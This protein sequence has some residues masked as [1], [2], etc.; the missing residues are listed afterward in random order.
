MRSSDRREPAT[1]AALSSLEARVRHLQGILGEF[2]ENLKFAWDYARSDAP[3]SLTKSRLIME[4]LL[5]RLYQSEMG[6]EPKKPLLGDMLADNQ[7]TRKIGRRIVVRMNTIRDM[8]NLGAHGITVAPDDAI[9]IIED[10][11]TVLEWYLARYSKSE[12]AAADEVAASD[13]PESPEPPPRDRANTAPPAGHG[14]EPHAVESGVRAR[15]ILSFKTSAGEDTRIIIDQDQTVVAGRLADLAMVFD[16]PKVSKLHAEFQLGGEGLA[17]YDLN[18]KNHVFVNDVPVKWLLL[19]RG[20]QVRL[21][22]SGPVI[23]VL[24][25][26]IVWPQT[27]SDMTRAQQPSKHG[28]PQTDGRPSAKTVADPTEADQPTKEMLARGSAKR[29]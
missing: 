18:S 21:S 3:S 4:T 9:R 17:V 5:V 14:E 29:L 27:E 19:N 22:K 2:S 24:E 10:L 16:H 23:E 12:A 1:Q 8:G 20:D 13:S 7:F 28:A 11:C 25:A 6:R 15:A 26:P